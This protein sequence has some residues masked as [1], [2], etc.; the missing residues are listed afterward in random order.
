MR[1]AL[2]PAS[3]NA[4]RHR[5]AGSC[6]TVRIVQNLGRLSPG[7]QRDFA[8]R[9]NWITSYRWFGA[10]LFGF[11]FRLRSFIVTKVANTAK[12]MHPI[13][14]TNLIIVPLLKSNQHGAGG[15]ADQFG[16]RTDSQY[17]HDEEMAADAPC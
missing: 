16:I 9:R 5:A 1:V 12:L 7:R 15:A 11:R 8:C 13:S 2:R 14:K 3:P 17:P 10:K 4:V 6:I